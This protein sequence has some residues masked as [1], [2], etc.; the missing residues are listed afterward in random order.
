MARNKGRLAAKKRGAKGA[1][2]VASAIAADINSGLLGN[3]AW[4]KQVEIE[5]R[6]RCTR[7]D[8]RRALEALAIRGV[9]QRIPQRGYYV[10][11]IDERS[12]RELIEVRVILETATVPSVVELAT[13]ADI[14]DLKRL[15]EKFARSIRHGDAA[16]RYYANRAFHVRLTEICGNRE[17]AK[18]AIEVRGHLPATPIAQWRSQ[19]Q[20]ERSCAEHFMMVDALAARDAAKLMHLLTIHI[21]QP[22]Q[23]DSSDQTIGLS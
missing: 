15:A 13:A 9:V 17:L 3:G 20:I 7:A 4:L 10:T 16:E 14:D 21:R 5:A 19:V 11:V 22:D 6:Y 2:A 23:Y 1:D 12:H 18:L 8:A